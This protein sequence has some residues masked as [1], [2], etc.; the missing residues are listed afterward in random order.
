MTIGTI[1]TGVAMSAILVGVAI[2]PIAPPGWCDWNT[3]AGP[4]PGRVCSFRATARARASP[5]ARA[6]VVD[7]V[8]AERPKEIFSSSW[9]G[10]G[11]RMLLLRPASR[12]QDDGCMCEVKAMMGIEGAICGRSESSSLVRP[13]NVMNSIV[14]CYVDCQYKT[15]LKVNWTAYRHDHSQIPM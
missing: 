9:I 6:T 11:M 8:G 7:V 3:S 10:A 1:E 14:S 12:G 2:A 13:E 15:W 4:R 5:R